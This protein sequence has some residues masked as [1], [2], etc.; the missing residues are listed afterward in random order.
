MKT[1]RIHIW[2]SQMLSWIIVSL[3]IPARPPIMNLGKSVMLRELYRSDLINFP[4][5]FE[6]W[7]SNGSMLFAA[8]TFKPVP[9]LFIPDSDLYL[10]FL[11]AGRVLFVGNSTDPWY[12]ANRQSRI[13]SFI[14]TGEEGETSPA[15]YMF[16]QSEPASPL[17]CTMREQFCS[18]HIPYGNCT[19]L[20]TVNDAYN[21]ALLPMADTNPEEAER[22]QWALDAMWEFSPNLAVLPRILGGQALHSRNSLN[23]GVQG[24]IPGDQ[25][26][27][28][29]QYWF[30]TALAAMQSA[31]IAAATGPTD[32]N[33]LQFATTPNTTAQRSV[34]SNQVRRVRR[35]T[36]RP[37]KD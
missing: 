33:I 8:S 23:Q 17:A 26:Q 14:L 31:F 11:S 9:E 15:K 37:E 27:Q 1:Y 16:Y 18:P 6:A 19:P 35:F 32:P 28:D 24:P 30:N 5:T 10:F 21:L 29:V 4:R 3:T 34:C 12:G 2:L 20:T 7:Y 25:W 36:S 22:L 13:Q